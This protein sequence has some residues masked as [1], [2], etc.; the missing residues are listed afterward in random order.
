MPGVKFIFDDFKNLINHH[1]GI[2]ERYSND[3][4]KFSIVFM[5]AKNLD[6]DMVRDSLEFVLRESD[7][8]FYMHECYFMLM[9]YTDK[10][11]AQIVQKGHQDFLGGE[12][13][14]DIVTF[15]DDGR[16][17]EELLERI[18]EH[19]QVWLEMAIFEL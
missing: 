17:V 7:A 16:T 18:D 19:I 1:I 8:I 13:D 2:I 3:S 9:P 12:V 15:P 4:Q 5:Y 11:G 14:S 6:S 10:K